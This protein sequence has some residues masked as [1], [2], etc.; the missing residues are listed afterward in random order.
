MKLPKQIADE[1]DGHESARAALEALSP[2]TWAKL[3]SVLEDLPHRVLVVLLA[4]VCVA[5][6][7]PIEAACALAN[8]SVRLMD[9]ME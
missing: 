9:A 8:K 1:L 3:I 5:Q 2:E 7:D 6:D 4:G